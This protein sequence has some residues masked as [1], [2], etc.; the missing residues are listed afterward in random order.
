MS[1]SVAIVAYLALFAS[2]GLVFVLVNLLIGRLVRPNNPHSEKLEVYEC[3]EPTIGSSFVQ[4]DLRFYVVALIFIV[5]EVEV[6]FMFPWA[7]VYG[8]ATHLLDAGTAPSEWAVVREVEGQGLQLTRDAEALYLELGVAQPGPPVAADVVA[9]TEAVRA[10]GHSLVLLA[11]LEMSV[12]FFILF[13]AFAYEWKTGALDW[14]RAVST[15]G[16][17][18]TEPAPPDAD[19]RPASALSA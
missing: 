17:A 14:V 2:V 5:F 7:A 19:V 13:L 4:F 6:A 18:F 16:V 9:A 8:K 11:F 15:D 1:S 12:F 3:G 10:G